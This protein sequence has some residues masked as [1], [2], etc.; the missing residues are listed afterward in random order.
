MNP[1]SPETPRKQITIDGRVTKTKGSRP[2]SS[3][4]GA[5]TGRKLKYGQCPTCKLGILERRRN[6]P[7]GGG[8]DAGLWRLSCTRSSALPPCRHYEAF[9]EDP[10][11]LW[12]QKQNELGRGPCPEC[13]IGKLV[14]KV[15]NPFKFTER[16]TE[17]SRRGEEDGCNYRQPITKGK[18]EATKGDINMAEARISKQDKAINM[19]QNAGNMDYEASNIN[20]DASNNKSITIHKHGE[21]EQTESLESGK[22][23]AGT[24]KPTALSNPAIEDLTVIETGNGLEDSTA[25]GSP[26]GKGKTIVDLTLD[27]DDED[28]Q[29]ETKYGS[30]SACYPAPAAVYPAQTRLFQSASPRNTEGAQ[31]L[32]NAVSTFTK[33]GPN[34]PSG[35]HSTLVTPRKSPIAVGKP[36]FSGSGKLAPASSTAGF[37]N[38]PT[39]PLRMAGQQPSSLGVVTP[40]SNRPNKTSS[41]PTRVPQKRG[42]EKDV[43]EDFDEFDELDSDLK[44][45][46]VELADKF[47]TPSGTNG[48]WINK[49]QPRGQINTTPSNQFTYQT[50]YQGNNPFTGHSTTPVRNQFSNPPKTQF[51][52]PGS[53]R[54]NHQA[55]NQSN[56]QASNPVSN[57]VNGPVNSPVNN[58]VNNNM[59]STSKNPWDIWE[60]N[61]QTTSQ[62]LKDISQPPSAKRQKRDEFDDFDDSDDQELLALAEKTE[63]QF[64]GGKK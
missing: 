6:N 18:A 42:R 19:D 8:P 32:K 35:H 29:D 24:P 59:N 50:G 51:T 12:A 56:N 20:G 21:A 55:A 11:I 41:V 2:K 64:F 57:P 36:P 9:N 38:T 44:D 53:S 1:Q 62:F 25:R 43:E 15:K 46:M 3:R 28:D 7:D 60:A 14:E 58:P 10:A 31:P 30:V 37:V 23:M 13:R 63:E 4:P 47:D 22:Q 39:K 52:A 61:R 49:T 33:S 45:A 54:V 40:N 5:S 17:C 34:G 26:K 27:D 16:Y 48:S